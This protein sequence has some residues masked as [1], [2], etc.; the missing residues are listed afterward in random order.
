MPSTRSRSSPHFAFGAYETIS[1]RF[2]PVQPRG[3]FYGPYSH[4]AKATPAL[5][6]HTTNDPATPYEWGRRVVRDLG[7]ARLLTYRGDGH[8]VVTDLNP[9]VLAALVPYLE[10]RTLPPAGAACDQDVPFGAQAAAAAGTVEA[11]VRWRAR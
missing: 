9:C 6:M 2:W 3:A 7:N 8:G 10:D 11:N 5:V 4:A 1:E